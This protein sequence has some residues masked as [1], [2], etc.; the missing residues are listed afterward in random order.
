MKTLNQCI[1]KHTYEKIIV[2]VILAAI[3][4][5]GCSPTEPGNNNSNQPD[6]TS[7]NFVWEKYT[8]GGGGGSSV[9]HDVAII[10]D[11]D[12]W[13]V[14]EIYMKDSLGNDDPIPYNAVHWNGSNWKLF[15]IKVRDYGTLTGY[16]PLRAVFGFSEKNIWF[17]SYAD[18]IKWDGNK[19]ESR[20]F[21]MTSFPFNGQ[22]NKMWGTNND[23]IYCVGRTGAIYYYTGN[24]WQKIESGTNIDIQDI[25]GEIDP[26]TNQ[27][28]I[29]AVASLQNYGRAL[30]LLQINNSTVTKT[31]T[32]GLHVNQHGIWFK[33]GKAFYV[34]GNGVYRK[35]TLEDTKWVLENSH[36]SL[37]KEAI[38]GNNWNDVVIVGDFGLV[39]HFNGLTWKHYNIE[40]PLTNFY[41]VSIKRNMVTAVGQ[42]GNEA[43]IIVGR[44][45]K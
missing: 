19:Y 44:R 31:D 3:G 8:F 27:T 11:T 9:L 7:H 16:F 28:I 6:I 22:V 34:V 32:S 35:N 17:A 41:S 2:V 43:V 29:L 21:F 33:A 23:N 45:G 40:L 39:S 30:D 15:R 37:Y 42:N 14:G 12:I 4:T 24:S 20:A 25:W 10:N 18:L 36:P 38:R 5:I 26:K 1:T 13:A